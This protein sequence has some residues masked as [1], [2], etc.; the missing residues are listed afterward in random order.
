MGGHNNKTELHLLWK[1]KPTKLER[2]T[3]YGT[4]IIHIKL[5]NGQTKVNL[6]N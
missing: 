1:R 3:A 4:T 2:T 5:Y 6:Q